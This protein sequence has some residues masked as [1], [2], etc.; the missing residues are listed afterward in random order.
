MSLA[1]PVLK[2]PHFDV[3]CK[4]TLEKV[5][6]RLLLP[7]QSEGRVLKPSLNHGDCWDGNT[8]MDMKTGD[9]FM[10][11]AFSFYVHI[12]YDTGN[13]RAP[14]H[15]LSNLAYIKNYKRSFLVSVP[16][17]TPGIQHRLLSNIGVYKRKIG[18]LATFFIL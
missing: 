11:D 6:P 12:E 18:M 4:L 5:V 3:V 14:R 15:R 1:K 9:A 17:K 16:G 13:W 8:A 7:L 2:W 10:F